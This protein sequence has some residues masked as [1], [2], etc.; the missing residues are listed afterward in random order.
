KGS[1]PV[2]VRVR[3]HARHAKPSKAGPTI[4]AVGITASF[5]FLYFLLPLGLSVAP[6]QRTANLIGITAYLPISV[7]LGHRAGTRVFAPVADWLARGAPEGGVDPAVV[8]RQGS[9]QT[10]I[11]GA[12]WVLAAVTFALLNAGYSATIVRPI[13]T[14]IV[15]C[16]ITSCGIAYLWTERVMRPAVT[17]ALVG[18]GS[19]PS[20]VLGVTSRLLL[21]W[22][23]GS[24]IPLL[25]IILGVAIPATGQEP[26]SRTAVA[27]LAVAGLV[28][29]FL[30]IRVAAAAVA[31]PIRSVASALREVGAGRLDTSVPVYDASDIG[32]LQS[33]F[34]T[35]VVGLRERDQ[36]RDLYGRQVGDAVAERALRE[37]VEFGGEERDVAVLFVDV[38]GSTGLADHAPPQEVVAQLNAFFSAVVAVVTDEGGWINKFQGDAALCVFG[39]PGEVPDAVSRAL[40]AARR[41]APA[42]SP[43]P[44]SA[45]IGVCSGRVVAGNIGALSRFEYTVI[46][47]AVNAAAR[48]TELAKDEPGRVLADA[49]MLAHANPDEAGC[50]IA[51][52]NVLL[53]GRSQPTELARPRQ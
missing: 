34:N 26:L 16:G 14:T 38:I 28:A 47:D 12:L 41:L 7:F 4:A 53:R 27:F 44:L 25:G 10:A 46:G 30:A 2:L 9:R 19:P 1:S 50:W 29:G 11:N 23:L 43:L 32:L 33:G 5:A 15:F 17:L 13:V 37:G 31:D 36:L 20:V 22:G 51:G 52:E 48:L 45:A 24:G 21:A 18:A 40:L 42:L 6:G 49:A 35:M 39:A 3:A 8:L